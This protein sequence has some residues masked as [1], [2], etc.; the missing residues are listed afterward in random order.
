MTRRPIAARE[1][2]GVPDGSARGPAATNP[3]RVVVRVGLVGLAIVT[4]AGGVVATLVNPALIDAGRKALARLD[5]RAAPK[6][7][8]SGED[9]P[10]RVALVSARF[11]DDSGYQLAGELT[12]KIEDRGSLPQVRSAVRVRAERGR[13][14]L[15]GQ[16]GRLEALPAGREGYDLRRAT[17]QAKIG[18]LFMYEGRFEDASRWLEKAAT[19]N[20]G[21]PADL[22]ANL[23][24]LRGVAAM[25][26]GEVDNCVACLG[27]SSCIFPIIP[28]ARHRQT[29]GSREAMGHFRAYLRQRPED[30]GVR[31]L[32][33]VAAMTLGESPDGIP[34]ELRLTPDLFASTLDIG[35]FPNVAPVVGLDTRGPNQFGGAV[36]DDFTGDGLPDVFVCSADCDLDAALFVNR[37]D[38]FEEL[39]TAAG[40]AG[41]TMAANASHADFDNDGKL[42]VLLLRGGWEAPYRLSLLRNRGGGAFQ[43]VTTTA[44]LATPIQSQAGAWGD[45]DNDGFV[46]LYVAGERHAEDLD[47]PNNSRLYRNN[48]DGT[49]ADIT[50]R[51]GVGNDRF[52]KG[53]AW[54]DYDGDGWPDLYVSNMRAA[55]RLY[56]NNGDGTFTDV[57]P[58]LGVTEPKDSFSCWFWDYDNDGRLD[59]F[60][61]GF[62][63]FLYDV[64][65]DALGRPNGGE[66]PRLYKNLGPQGFRDVT[67]EVGLGRVCLPMGSNFG[68]VDNDGYLDV[69][70]G[71]GLP[72]YS[73]LVPNRLFKNVGGRKFE[74]ISISSGTAHLQKG[75][76]VAFADWDGD[77][78]LDL[79]EEMGGA[80]PGDRAHNVL[81]QNP[82]HGRHWLGLRLAGT[83]TN[84]AAIGAKLRVDIRDRQGRIRSIFREVNAG[85]SYGGNSFVQHIGL[86]EAESADTIEV[87]WP[88]SRARQAFRHV[89]ADRTITII[90]GSDTYGTLVRRPPPP[91]G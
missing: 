75:H 4:I 40:L 73:A 53:A 78:D 35:R 37:G 55:N 7:G 64:I 81:F 8:R 34:A 21:I 84:R 39:G 31:W 44:G 28:E 36:F 27:P 41:Q 83:R 50:G 74:D 45:F 12:P 47:S 82:G 86:D 52:A 2:R 49:F 22:T 60:V 80:A 32:L 1:A 23:V 19:E 11:L 43:D 29:S 67:T 18:M 33:G 9:P 54:G 30:V 70:L 65:A 51:A 14:T 79:F 25:R 88:V 10:P 42:D 89:P 77:G 48:G 76:G 72:N 66:R 85:S 56:R 91:R 69:Y 26:R 71:T 58:A 38:R 61:A 16:L 17:L 20:P 13:S 15:L 57:A 3:M 59:L 68:D 62:R 87:T 6:P 90:E 24:A 46:D 5:P 63:G